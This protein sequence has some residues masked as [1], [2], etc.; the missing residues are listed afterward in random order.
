MT[1]LKIPTAEEL[2]LILFVVVPI[3]AVCYYFYYYL[4]H[5][6]GEME[7]RDYCSLKGYVSYEYV[8]PSKGNL[9]KS[10]VKCRCKTKQNSTR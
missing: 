9:G 4:P 6:E 3:F 8:H 7:C 1:N 10:R 2:L 5:K